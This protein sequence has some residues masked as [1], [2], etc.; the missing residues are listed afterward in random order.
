[1]IA[2]LLCNCGGAEL[3]ARQKLMG[4]G[5]KDYLAPKVYQGKEA[6]LKFLE[7]FPETE[8]EVGIAKV[9]VDIH[10]SY[11][12]VFGWHEDGRIRWTD[13]SDPSVVAQLDVGVIVKNYWP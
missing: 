11:A 12:I 5:M 6:C 2:L 1:M 13:V 9:H 10:S 4:A 3:L 8:K 7:K